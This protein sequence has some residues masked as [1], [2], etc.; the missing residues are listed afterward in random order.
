[1][2]FSFDGVDGTGK[3]TQ[4]ELF[5]SWLR[6]CGH[7]V[8]TYRDPGGTKLGE[9]I[10]EILLTS[11]DTPIHRRS[12]ML[13]YMASR[14]QLVEE[15]LKPALAA[16]KAIVTD[17]FLLANVVY[18][19]YAGGLD[20]EACKAVGQVA[21]G[22]LLPDHTFVLDMPADRAAERIQREK[23]RMEQQGDDFSVR[24]RDGYLAEAKLDPQR[25]TVIDADQTIEAIHGDVKAAVIRAFPQLTG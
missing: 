17:R 6:E 22:G 8:E 15:V 12:E 14:T 20:I 16:G 10:R 11:E 2:F 18:Q 7:E 23:D 19:G 21:T 5:C 4:V 3:S 13:L 24:V 25:I 9:R 1:M